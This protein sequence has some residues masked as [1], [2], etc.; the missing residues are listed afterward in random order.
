MTAYD[1]AS[2]RQAGTASCVNILQAIAART[3][4][5]ADTI[6]PRVQAAVTGMLGSAVLPE[7]PLMEA[8]LDS[9][10]AV[11]LR[12]A[13]SEAFQLQ[14][15]ATAI[16][17]YPTVAALAHFISSHLGASEPGAMYCIQRIGCNMLRREVA[18]IIGSVA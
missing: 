13:L 17:D 4:P 1:Y 7:Q 6:L 10:G 9:L 5:A 8:G 15:P 3:A 14:L 11:E 12:N 16:F 18:V 2:L